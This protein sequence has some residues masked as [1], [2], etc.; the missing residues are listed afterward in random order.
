MKNRKYPLLLL[1]FAL[2]GANSLMGQTFSEYDWGGEMP[3]AGEIPAEMQQEDAVI[4][5]S[6]TYS[7]NEFS[8][9]FPYIEQLANYKE[10]QHIKFLKA[11]ATE[12]YEH[13]IIPK[14]KGRIGDFVQMKY[15]DV[16]IRRK[17]GSLEDL[18]IRDLEQPKFEED[19]ELY[20]TQK[21]AYIYKLPKLEPGDEMEQ[22]TVIESKFPDQG[23]IVTLYKDYPV[24]ESEFKISVP[25]S[26][27]LKGQIYNGMPAVDIKERGEQRFYTWKMNNLKAVPEANSSGTIF[28]T[29]L[30]H[31]VY[32]LDFSAL[33]SDRSMKVNNFSDLLRQYSTD[34]M[35]VRIRS[36]KKVR[37]FYETLFAE[38]AK[39]FKKSAEELSV[40]EKAYL[41]N[42]F[43]VRELQLVGRLKDF[44]ES[45]G[46]DYFLTNKKADFSSLLCIY[47]DF[48]ERHNIEFYF[49]IGKSRFN[50]PFDKDY[51][52]ATQ[53]SSYLF[54][55]K[56]ENG[57]LFTITPTGGLNELP[58][59][60]QNTSCFMLDLNDKKA[61]LQ[62]INFND[63]VLKDSKNNSRKR[64]L[65]LTVAK[66]GDAVI[67]GD[68]KLSGLFSGQRSNWVAANKEGQD[69]LKLALE[70]SLSSRFDDREV[71]VKSVE[72][73]QLNI[74]QPYA[75][76]L[77][78]EAEVKG[79][80]EEKEGKISLKLKDWLGHSI[81]WV[82][83]AD[84]RTL[85]YHNRFLGQDEEEIF[86]VFESPRKVEEIKSLTAKKENDK[87]T[88]SLKVS[89][90]Q[91][92]VVRI[93]SSYS[94]KQLDLSPKEAKKQQ[95]INKLWD[96]LTDKRIY[97]K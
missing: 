65:Q 87:A 4:L 39:T 58:A 51:P 35:D 53:I 24:L 69:S 29:E 1:S 2:L 9:T 74:V 67:K 3:K 18:V 79:L 19:D 63:A 42:N 41:M 94:V 70:R 34:F 61:S 66:N 72:I 38:G 93:N 10:Y 75:F 83:N 33:R 80:F 17:D 86:L 54:V 52:S 84:K 20:E 88:Y 8:G 68:L 97:L 89:Q 27:G 85:D 5:K 30:E 32:E 60:L 91:P 12:D 96:E 46:I 71:T 56:D 62:S 11:E 92:N 47:R 36:K 50:G 25:T 55:F 95:E 73:K 28:T 82:S 6:S 49:G 81:R 76:S 22:I 16:R 15:V 21:N 57:S 45:E 59:E 64:R 43:V 44:E 40:V 7:S 77:V 23:R 14:F 13:L 26:V 48:F 78:Y 31:F 37:K 90:M